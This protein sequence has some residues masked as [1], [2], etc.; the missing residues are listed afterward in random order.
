MVEVHTEQET[1]CS[2]KISTIQV[3]HVPVVVK[4]VYHDSWCQVFY[5][6]LQLDKLII[7][8]EAIPNRSGMLWESLLLRTVKL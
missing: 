3:I 6:Y 5:V 2:K 1:T 7:P 4:P 8:S